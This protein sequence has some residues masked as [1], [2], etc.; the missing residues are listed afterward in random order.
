MNDKNWHM[1]EFIGGCALRRRRRERSKPT[2]G[3]PAFLPQ[4]VKDGRRRVR[5]FLPAAG[6]RNG[7][8]VNNVG[9]NGNYWSSTYNNSNNAYN[10]NFNSGNVNPQNNNNRNNGFSV[11]LACPAENNPKPF[12]SSLSWRNVSKILSMT[13]TREQLM[14]D[15]MAAYLDA[16]RHKRNKPYQL[17][18][19]ANL[20]HNIT[21]LCDALMRRDYRAL[22]SDCFI[23]TEPKKR[24]VFAAHFRDRV[25]HHLYYNYTHR[26]FERTFIHDCYSCIKGRGTHFG[27]NRLRQH[28]ISESRNYTRPCHVLKMDIRGYFMSINRQRLLEI[29]LASLENMA[30][31]KVGKYRN[32]LW[33]DVVD[34]DFLRYLT[35]EIVLLDPTKDCRIIGKPSEWAGLPREKSLFHSPK[36][37]GL[38]IGNLTSQ[39]YSNVYLNEFDQFMKRQMHCTHYG[40]YVDDFYVVGHDRAW[41]ES[42]VK[43]ASGFLAERLGLTINDGKTEI[44]PVERGIEFLGGFV[45]PHRVYISRGTLL[46]MDEKL[47]ALEQSTDRDHIA[48]ALN[49]YCGVLSH[50]DSFN[51][52]QLMLLKRHRFTDYGMFDLDVRHFYC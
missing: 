40:R 9:S 26:L 12:F 30:G 5:V 50:W 2:V 14:D 37:C 16:R 21:Y 20:R 29:S 32:T 39:L 51:V 45:L 17:R 25:V 48:K 49:S 10:L 41:L 18:F 3:S 27:I 47:F 42:L 52:R 24:E 33:A 19:E 46:R 35:R 38:P 15:L 44:L 8:S 28:V 31:H 34:M 11:R 13:L 1:D 22:P 23:I 43:P 4:G 7:T 36:G 6:N